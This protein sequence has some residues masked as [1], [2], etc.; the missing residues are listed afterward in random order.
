MLF[1]CIFKKLSKGG[2][3]GHGIWGHNRFD[4]ACQSPFNIPSGIVVPSGFTRSAIVMVRRYIRAVL[5]FF[6]MPVVI[7][8][9]DI[10]LVEEPFQHTCLYHLQGCVVNGNYLAI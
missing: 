9:V 7:L 5:V 10:G 6:K 4:P 2:L 8:G 1:G 3:G